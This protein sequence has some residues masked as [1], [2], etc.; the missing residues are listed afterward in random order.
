M[1]S[2]LVIDA[3]MESRFVELVTN[4]DDAKVREMPGVA[5]E[6]LRVTRQRRGIDLATSFVPSARRERSCLHSSSYTAERIP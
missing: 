3:A 6:V 5:D 1:A 4:T 2:G